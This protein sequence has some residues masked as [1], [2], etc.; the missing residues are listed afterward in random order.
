MLGPDIIPTVGLTNP[1]SVYQ[2]LYNALTLLSVDDD[3]TLQHL[4]EVLMFLD[5]PRTIEGP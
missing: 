5:D 4:V 3:K 1:A 2:G